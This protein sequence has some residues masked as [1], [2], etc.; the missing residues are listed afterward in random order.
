[1]P[2]LDAVFWVSNSLYSDQARHLVGPDLGQTVCIYYQQ[3]TKV[4]ASVQTVNKEKLL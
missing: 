4:S 3:M 2:Y 1:M